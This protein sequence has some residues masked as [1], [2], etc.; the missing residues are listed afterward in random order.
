MIVLLVCLLAGCSD[1]AL[2]AQACCQSGYQCASD[3]SSTICQPGTMGGQSCAQRVS[4]YDCGVGYYQSYAGQTFCLE[5]PDGYQCPYART[6]TPLIMPTWYTR[7]QKRDREVHVLRLWGGILPAVCRTHHLRCMSGWV[8]V[9][10]CEN[11]QSRR[12]SAGYEKWPKWRGQISLLRMRIWLLSAVFR[13]DQLP[14]VPGRI[15]LPFHK[16]KFPGTMRFGLGC[17][18]SGTSKCASHERA[19]N[20]PRLHSN[21]RS[22]LDSRNQDGR[23]RSRQ[24]S[25]LCKCVSQY[26]ELRCVRMGQEAKRH[27]RTMLRSLFVVGDESGCFCNRRLMHAVHS[28]KQPSAP[29]RSIY[30]SLLA[31]AVITESSCGCLMCYRI[32]FVDTARAF[33]FSLD[34]CTKLIRLT[35]DISLSTMEFSRLATFRHL[36]P[37]RV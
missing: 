19:I 21:S 14:C 1:I 26:G 15:Q 12:M 2:A 17:G 18:A 5:C 22:V 4:C 25:R 29:K 20:L 24:P 16:H 9:S 34:W 37:A 33:F 10:K 31:I 36:A 35:S 28:R 32:S 7:R 6:I 23:K 27:S 3:G 30:F 8:H 11:Q 13:T